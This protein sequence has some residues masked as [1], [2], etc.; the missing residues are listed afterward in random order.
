MEIKPKPVGITE[1][2]LRDGHQSLL[3][4]RMRTEDMLP[5]AEQLDA[6][7]Y[8]S[9]EVWGGATFDTALRFLNEDPWVR[10]R[11]LKRQMPKTPL[12]ML[13]RGQNVVGYRHYADDVVE[14]F[15]ELAHKNGVAI[16]RIFDALNDV[17]NLETAM[18]A[19]RR[20]GGH[21]QGTMSYTISPVHTVEKY[22]ETARELV[23]VGCDSLCVKDMAGIITPYAAY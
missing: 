17:R 2:V 5:V 21:V 18:R 20:V 9:L 7:G 22:V 16:F 12:Q 3:A 1:T 14:K 8:H 19:A 10:L 11:I 6:I 13:L 15:V 4:T 23:E